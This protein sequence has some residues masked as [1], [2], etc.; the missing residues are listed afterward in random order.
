MGNLEYMLIG[1]AAGLLACSATYPLDTMRTQMSVTGG[2][3]GNLLSVGSQ[4]VKAGG[5][6]ALYKGFGAT[7]TSDVLGSGLGFMNYEV[8]QT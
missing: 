6:G 1:S 3:K 2:L 4:I 7:L 5:V 8:R